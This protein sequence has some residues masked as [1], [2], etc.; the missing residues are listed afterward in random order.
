MDCNGSGMAD[1]NGIC[2][3][4]SACIACE[5]RGAGYLAKRKQ[6]GSQPQAVQLIET[7]SHADSDDLSVLVG[8]ELRARGVIGRPLGA[9]SSKELR[10][11]FGVSRSVMQAIIRKLLD[12]GTIVRYKITEHDANGRAVPNT[13]YLK[14]G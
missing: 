13:V 10:K 3:Q 14:L 5:H 8:K 9:K 1:G 7:L 4:G 12:D 6:G 11:E 2:T